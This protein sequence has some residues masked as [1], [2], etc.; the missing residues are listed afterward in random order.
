MSISKKK[1]IE[2]DPENL[3]YA[4]TDEGP[5]V[6]VNIRLNANTKKAFFTLCKIQNVSATEILTRMIHT[7]IEDYAMRT[8]HHL[9]GSVCPLSNFM[10]EITAACLL[11]LDPKIATDYHEKHSTKK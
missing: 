4:H 5:E 7:F 11:Q 8:P 6:Q 3:I 2:A 9:D 1:I 10:H